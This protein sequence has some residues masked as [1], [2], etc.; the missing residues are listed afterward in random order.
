MRY[1]IFCT[2]FFCMCNSSYGVVNCPYENTQ[3]SDAVVCMPIQPNGGNSHIIKIVVNDIAIKTTCATPDTVSWVNNEDAP[4]TYHVGIN[5]QT[6]YQCD[7]FACD[8]AVL[9]NTFTFT[10]SDKD[11]DR[12]YNAIPAYDSIDML[13]EYGQICLF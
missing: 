2:I 1:F 11:N 12:K 10:L 9:I 3:T 4:F 6:I 7:N 13:P 5:N 8:N